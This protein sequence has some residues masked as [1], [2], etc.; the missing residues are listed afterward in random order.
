MCILIYFPPGMVPNRTHLENSAINNPDGYGW[1]IIA[2]GRILSGHSMDATEAIDEFESMRGQ[3]PDDEA[4]FHCRITTHGTT[5]LDNCHPFYINGRRDMILAHN[6]MMPCQPMPG[7]KR[8]DTRI[9]A[10]DI[11]M[12]DF[13]NLD[14][15][16]TFKRLSAWVGFSK[17]LILSTNKVYRQSS[18][19][20]NEHM[21]TWEKGVWY[22]NTSY[23]PDPWAGCYSW[24]WPKVIGS[25]PS[26]DDDVE[27][28]C[29]SCRMS[30][31]WCDCH[32]PVFEARAV[33]DHAGEENVDDPD[34]W[35]CRGCLKQGWINPFT[36]VCGMCKFKWCCDMHADACLCADSAYPLS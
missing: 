17:V 6:G 25:S 7:D 9:F 3:F 16:K 14:K 34:S 28:L 29:T 15:A 36:L 31:T 10:E 13:R 12:R 8:S 2:A 20:V 19:L 22:S 24:E 32:M 11:L 18:Y 26:L 21:G 35:V 23:L 27:W 1:A 4:L 5:S 33:T 30:Q